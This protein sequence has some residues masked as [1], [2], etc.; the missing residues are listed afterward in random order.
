MVL[1]INKKTN[2]SGFVLRAYVLMLL[3]VCSCFAFAQPDDEALPKEEVDVTKTFN[4][5]VQEAKKYS[6][7]PTLPAPPENSRNSI[8]DLP[9]RLLA[10]EYEA[11]MIKPI[12]MRQEESQATKR[13]WAK[14]GYGV[15]NQP[16]IDFKLNNGQSDKID[17]NIHARHHSANNHQRVDNQR[18]GNTDAFIDGT[19]YTDAFAVGGKLGFDL[20]QH[21]FYGHDDT[22]YFAKSQVFQRFSTA[23]GELR[24]LNTYPTKGNVNY[25]LT[26]DFHVTGDRYQAWEFRPGFEAGLKKMFDDN[27]VQLIVDN[28]YRYFTD[29]DSISTRRQINNLLTFK[30]SIVLNVKPFKLKVGAYLGFDDD[31]FV[32]Y[33]DLEASVAVMDGTITL[34][35]GW[36][37]EIQQ[38]QFR[39][40]GHYNPFI[41][42]ILNIKN[43]RIQNRYGG[44]K[45]KFAGVNFEGRVTQKPIEN[46]PMYLTDYSDYMRRFDIVYDSIATIL[47][48]DGVADFD[49]LKSIK[50]TISA[51]YNIYG[52]DT[53]HWHLPPLETDVTARYSYNDQIGL[54]ASLYLASGSRYLSREG[55]PRTLSPLLDLNVGGTYRINDNF[56]LFVDVNNLLSSNYQRWHRYPQLGLNF[57]VGVMFRY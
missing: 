33:P 1:I 53:P 52:S 18:F 15:P 6:P 25:W 56:A 54:S 39:E 36:N 23:F 41:K 19:Y 40:F 30:P 44:L 20:D 43:T 51:T 3:L 57:M 5:A 46:L 42:S 22:L 13:F 7:S 38:G 4:A 55:I 47:S 37:G 11:P 26:G 35:G 2:W 31:L 50:T 32:P 48:L 10:L 21:H 27:W 16:Y 24:F 28:H 34:F 9:E 45:G 49:I 8:Y 14:V 12:A 17:F 29:F